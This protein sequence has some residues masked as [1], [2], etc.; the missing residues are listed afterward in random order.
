MDL[1]LFYLF[2]WGFFLLLAGYF[3]PILIKNKPAARTISWLIILATT[4]FSMQITNHETPLFRMLAIVSLQLFSMKII[5]M[6]ETYSGKPR[7]NF[8]QWIAFFQGWFGMRPTLFE[9]FW[10]KT[11]PAVSPLLRKGISRIFLGVILLY[12]SK[13]IENQELSQFFLPQILMLAGISFILHFGILNLATAFW[14]FFGVNVGPLFCSPA[15]SKSLQEF[16][17]K[18]WNLAFS[19]MTALIV[20]R[21]LKDKFGKTGAMISAFLV[22]GLL[23]EIAI[24]GPVKSGFGLPMLY[25]SLHAFAMF[26]ESEISFLKKITSHVFWSRVWVFLWLVLP[27][28]LLFHRDF[29]NLVIVPLRNFILYF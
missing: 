15:G 14:R 13:Q 16:W 27:M 9:R 21:P 5:V 10:S 1:T 25:F 22:S 8:I 28:P 23:H 20:Y 11:L 4:L 7:L 24:S 29:I 2:A 17:G 19:E 12:F 18:R 3:L 6:V 26:L